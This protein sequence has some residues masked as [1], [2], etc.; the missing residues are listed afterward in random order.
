MQDNLPL[1]DI[2]ISENW[3][4]RSGIT[5]DVRVFIRQQKKGLRSSEWAVENIY[6]G[7]LSLLIH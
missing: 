2:K 6:D 4:F 7:W 5:G 3:L 1:E